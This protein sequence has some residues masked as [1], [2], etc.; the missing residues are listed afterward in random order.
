MGGDFVT[1]FVVETT[2]V[3]LTGDIGDTGDCKN[4]VLAAAVA[5][6]TV[7]ALFAPGALLV[8]TGGAGGV[9]HD[10]RGA[11][12][13]LGGGT[14][15][16]RGGA[17]TG[18][19]SSCTERGASIL[20]SSGADDSILTDGDVGAARMSLCVGDRGGVRM[21]GERGC[22]ITTSFSRYTTSVISLVAPV[23]RATA[24]SWVASVI[25]MPLI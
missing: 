7:C 19:D 8:R 17:K 25:D 1:V 16:A 18:P 20:A 11:T 12:A 10:G 14:T 5:E 4:E 15:A 6:I 22:S 23:N 3:P 2:A 21:V 9:A 13:G 24:S